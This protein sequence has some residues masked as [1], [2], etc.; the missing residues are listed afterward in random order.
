MGAVLKQRFHDTGLEHP[1]GFFSRALTGSERNYS[2]YEVEL[3]AVVR[4]VEHFRMFLLCKEFLLRN[5]HAAL[6]NLLRRD[7]PLT[8]RVERWILCLSEYNFK[9]EYQRGQDNV[10]ADVLSRLPFAGAKSAEKSTAHDQVPRDVNS[11]ESEVPR[12]NPLEDSFSALLISNA[13]SECD[14]SDK[15][16]SDSEDTSSEYDFEQSECKIDSNSNNL[17]E[18]PEGPLLRSFYHLDASAPLIDLPLSCE[19]IQVNDFQISTSDEFA[20]RICKP[21]F[22]PYVAA[23]FSFMQ[24]PFSPQ[25]HFGAAPSTQLP[26]RVPPSAPGCSNIFTTLS[27]A[28]AFASTTVSAPHAAIF[29]F[30]QPTPGLLPPPV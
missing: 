1:V 3:F 17:D 26:R 2:A 9:I 22:C 21:L 29:A 11:P 18:L 5:D 10:I 13:I 30:P 6:R 24:A 25:A 28:S 27:L 7:L 23:L 20:S 8:T 14:E 4:A 16:L 15:S 19:R 12:P